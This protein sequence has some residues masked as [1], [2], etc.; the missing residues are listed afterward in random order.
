MVKEA[1]PAPSVK[2]LV[3]ATLFVLLLWV[4]LCVMFCFL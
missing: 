1:V 3:S 4:S 2:N